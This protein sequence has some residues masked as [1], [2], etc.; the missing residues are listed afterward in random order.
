MIVMLD[1]GHGGKDPGAVN[2]G[3][4]LTEAAINLSVAKKTREALQKLGAACYL[5]RNSDVF[6]DLAER[7]RMSNALGADL[8][9]SLH[10]NAAESDAAHGFESYT[11]RGVTE[12]DEFNQI[13]LD[14]WCATFPFQSV[15]AGGLKEANFAVLRGTKAP[16]ILIE[17]G[18]ISNAVEA[19]ML[20]SE[21]W[22]AH[23]AHTIAEAVKTWHAA[24]AGDE[25]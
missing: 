22:Q 4:R 3:L 13:L 8:F 9:I 17:M 7:A 24:K 5:T 18:F 15:R 10:C 20:D 19:K 11:S 1:A 2:R 21:E 16:A 23:A 14:T 25:K 6:V 12:A